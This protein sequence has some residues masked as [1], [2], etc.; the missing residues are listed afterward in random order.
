[1]SL[2]ARLSIVSSRVASLSLAA[3]GPRGIQGIPGISAYEL[4]VQ[5]GFVG[6]QAEWL[7]SLAGV[8]ASQAEAE[9]G[10]DNSARMTPLRTFQ[11]IASWVSSNLSLSWNAITGKPS[12]F[13]PAPHGHSISDVSGLQSA[14]D[15]KQASGNS[16][17]VSEGST[18]LYFTPARAVAALASTLLS[19]ATQS[20]VGTQITSAITALGLGTASTHAAE[21]FDPAG[22]ASSAKSYADG[23]SGTAQTN[24]EEY[25]AALVGNISPLFPLGSCYFAD[26][27]TG[28]Y[29]ARY[30]V[31]DQAGTLIG[32]LELSW[33]GGS[34]LVLVGVIAQDASG[35]PL[36]HG[37]F[38]MN[39][40]GDG[41]LTSAVCTN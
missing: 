1:M 23:V 13:P 8:T 10:T 30:L 6:T 25:A 24:A 32:T 36:P 34:T 41:N 3:V 2:V 35:T 29:P 16:D 27:G 15:G 26:G 37:T 20:W 22:A 31:K 17:T 40:D 4:A 33:D 39:Y 12:T 38:N 7:A 11:A 14:L 5:N 18:N 28:L 19:Y 9:S 21:D